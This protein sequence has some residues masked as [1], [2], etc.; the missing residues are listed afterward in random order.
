MA[1]LSERLKLF[2]DHLLPEMSKLKYDAMAEN[3]FRYY[4]G[5]CHLFYEDLSAGKKLPASPIT[6]ICGDLHLENYGSYKADNKL[7]Y[8]DLNDFDESILAPAAWELARMVTSIFIAFNALDIEQEKANNMAQLFIKTYA[9]TLSKGKATSIEPRTA[10]GIVRD[11]LTAA[12]ESKETIILQKCTDKK[13]KKVV[14][15]L[16]GESQLKIPKNLRLVLMDHVQQ[17]IEKSSDSPYN[18]KVKDAVFRLAGTGSIGVKRYLFLLKSTNTK[19]KYLLVDMKQSRPSS[20]SPYIDVKQPEWESD[21]DRIISVQRRMQNMSAS[22]LSSTLFKDEPFV[23]QELQPVK[24]AIKFKLIRDQY[25]DIYQVIDDM[26][27]LT[28]SAQLRSGGMNGSATI[29]ELKAFGNNINWQQALFDYCFKYGDKVK[30]DYRQYLK[31]YK[32]G[33]FDR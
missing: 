33:V 12:A 23:I 31:D 15:S 1:K 20:L 2:N 5:T 13:K 17:W 6:W 18:Y 28:A 7:V 16:S 32:N 26:A 19:N 21:G 11:F 22:L 25:R 24:D 4:R 29:D 8:F 10:K 30:T 27:V 14:L 9:A 3:L